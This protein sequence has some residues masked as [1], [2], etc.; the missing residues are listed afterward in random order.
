MIKSKFAA[1]CAVLALASGFAFAE[2]EFSFSNKV[3]SDIVN[4]TKEGDAD[5]DSEFA[6]IKNKSVFEFSS[7]KV[8]AMVELVFW[9][10]KEAG[11][12]GDDVL[13]L[14]H[15]EGETAGYD[16]GDTFVEVRP[17]DFLGF[18]FH[19]KMWTSGSYFPIWDDNASA[20]NMGSD[21]GAV[22]LPLEG[23]KIG[24]G[25]DFLS[26]FN[27]SD[28]KPVVNF[29]AEYANEVFALGAAVRNVADADASEN[30]LYEADGISFGVYASLLKV[31]GLVLNAGFGYNTAVEPDV[32]KEGGSLVKGNIASLT[33]TYEKDAF[34]SALDFATNF[35]NSDDGEYDFYIAASAGY[36]VIEDLSLDC[37]FATALDAESDSAKKADAR[38]QIN[39]SATYTVGNHEFSAGVNVFF[40]EDFTKV[41][42]PIYWK[43]AL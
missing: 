38:F 19:E 4:I 25:L 24:A 31:E 9:T 14:G 36:N 17:F 16:F 43:Y 7:D 39:P 20:G 12:D 32:T 18:E 40:G 42:F 8:N 29:G 13:A 3:S 26:V 27:D 22:I 23:L 15:P 2:S 11:T 5:T 35:G 41:N 6:G 1:A 37:A 33:G 34:H 28:V 21:F 10:T 30:D